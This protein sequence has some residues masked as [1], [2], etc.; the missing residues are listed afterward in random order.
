MNRR[1]RNSMMDMRHFANKAMDSFRRAT[2][3]DLD[4][5]SDTHFAIRYLVLAVGEAANR[6]GSDERDRSRFSASSRKSG[7]STGQ[8]HAAARPDRP[9]K[10]LLHCPPPGP[11]GA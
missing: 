1:D 4:S 8:R 5:D 3:D 6:V 10:R 9:S 2:A 7:A 11:E